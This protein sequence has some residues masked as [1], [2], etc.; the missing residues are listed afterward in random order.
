MMKTLL[1]AVLAL[2]VLSLM[3]EAVTANNWEQE[4][5][6]EGD[7]E[8]HSH[9]C[10]YMGYIAIVCN[11]MPENSSRALPLHYSS[12]LAGHAIQIMLYATQV[13]EN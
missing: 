4:T 3:F 2:A 6:G 11:C 10:A 13:W 9:C 7:S 12:I 1:F 5:L 8:Y